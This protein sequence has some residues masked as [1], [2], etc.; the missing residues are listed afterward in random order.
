MVKHDPKIKENHTKYIPCFG[1]GL[2]IGLSMRET[3]QTRIYSQFLRPFGPATN[4][5][6]H[7]QNQ[8]IFSMTTYFREKKTVS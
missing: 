7:G 6:K 3:R 1:G 4:L 5:Q 2:Q 8:C